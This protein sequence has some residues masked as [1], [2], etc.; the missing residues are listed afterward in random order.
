MRV[1]SAMRPLLWQRR[2]GC[3]PSRPG[4]PGRAGR[5]GLRRHSKHTATRW[6][7]SVR[8]H[9][10]TAGGGSTGHSGATRTKELGLGSVCRRRPLHL[11]ARDTR[12]TAGR[13]PLRLASS[14]PPP[15]GQQPSPA[16]AP[17]APAVP[18]PAAHDSSCA[19]TRSS[20]GTHRLGHAYEAMLC[21]G[22]KS[23][24]WQGVGE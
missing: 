7:P 11:C 10:A 18:C 22:A 14:R 23:E 3:S 4:A 15:A 13:G 12:E 6:S 8:G 5:A 1:P 2:G 16:S 17:A 21:F 9:T 19:T 20:T 24:A